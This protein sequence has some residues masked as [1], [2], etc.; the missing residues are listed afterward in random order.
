M[1]LT[2]L[3][4]IIPTLKRPDTLYWT[5]KTV[6]EQDYPNF[7][8]LVS[9]NFSNDNTQ[10]VVSSFN[11]DRLT[12]IKTKSKLSMSHHWEFA[13]SHITDG[14]LTI[15]GDDDGLLPGSL[16]KISKIIQRHQPPAIGW[17]FGNFNWKGLPP[18]FMVPLGGCYR[19]V[20][21]KKEIDTLFKKSVY[22]TIQFPSLYGG[23]IKKDLID[24]LKGKF[25]GAFFHSRIPDFFSGGIIAAN[26]EKYIRLEYPITINATSKHST[27]FATVSKTSEQNAFT[28]L[29]K[30]D[31]SNIPF[32]PSLVFVRSNAIPI[33]EAMLQVKKLEPSFPELNIKNVLQDVI[34]EA[35]TCPSREIYDEFI[36]GINEMGKVN[37]IESYTDDIIRQHPYTPLLSP[38]VKNKFSPIT[39]TVYI[40]T[41]L[42]SIENVYDACK[43]A[44]QFAAA[45]LKLAKSN[46]FISLNSLPGFIRYIKG[47][48][49]QV[50]KGY[51]QN[52]RKS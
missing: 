46:L 34:H 44:F 1:N 19:I 52:N 11:D 50:Y 18:Y 36:A 38:I 40:N 25:G 3:H 30:N 39:N 47:K 49:T 51:F 43:V 29:K 42:S 41:T 13:L 45:E 32:H 16:T 9:D 6:L 4:I 22:N 26:V 27:G 48:S 33:A 10:D 24:K 23:F 35:A 21:A 15:L 7:D 28:D 5:L 14:Y 2:K 12:Y 31:A 20:D 8:V 37:N 17:R